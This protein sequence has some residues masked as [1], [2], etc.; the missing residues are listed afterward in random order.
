MS[1]FIQQNLSVIVTAGVILLAVILLM[2]V[3]RAISPRVS[4]RRGQRL[5]ISEYHEIDKSRRLVLIRRDNTEHLVLIG[6]P[7]D[8]LIE[9]GIGTSLQAPY[10]PQPAVREADPLPP[11]VPRQAPRPAVF[12]DRKP[13]P[14]RAT[15]GAPRLRDE[16]P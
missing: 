2:V 9:S 8:L 13:P 14:L 4:G 3:W 7:Q 10:S 1:E 12:G 5:G 16:E 15:E 6:G 11:I